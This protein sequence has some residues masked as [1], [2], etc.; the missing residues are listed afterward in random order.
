MTDTLTI[1]NLDPSPSGPR[2]AAVAGLLIVGWGGLMTWAAARGVFV[3]A[4]GEIPLPMIGAVLTPPLLFSLAYLVA[5]SVRSFA[6]S[7]DI[8]LLTALQ[9]WRVLGFVFLALLSID[10]LPALFALPAGLGDVAVG[11]AAPFV[12]MAV[13]HK[14]AGWQ[15][16]VFW[17][18]VSGLLDFGVAVW[19]GLFAAQILLESGAAQNNLMAE[20]PMSL[21]PAAIV[22]I[23]IILHIIS[24]VQLRRISRPA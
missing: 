16:R 10:T 12:L 23:F 11:L 17:L 1:S 7:I 8:R 24:F 21:I 22:P 3:Q 14:R 15:R 5:P 19:S 20:L 6:L 2:G 18:N 9:A 13:I 4:S